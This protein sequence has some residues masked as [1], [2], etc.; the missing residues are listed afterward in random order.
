MVLKLFSGKYFALFHRN[1]SPDD[2]NLKKFNSKQERAYKMNSLPAL[3]AHARGGGAGRG[4]A[5]LFKMVGRTNNSGAELPWWV[6]LAVFMAVLFFSFCCRLCLK[7]IIQLRQ[8]EQE[9]RVS[10]NNYKSKMEEQ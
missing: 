1:T 4:L 6:I 8:G 7:P 3:T 5:R 10:R 9:N 2:G